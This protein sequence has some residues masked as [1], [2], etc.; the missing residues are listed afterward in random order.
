M[1]NIPSNLFFLAAGGVGRGLLLK[2]L[3]AAGGFI[4]ALGVVTEKVGLLTLVDVGVDGDWAGLLTGCFDGG[5]AAGGSAPWRLF[6]SCRSS[7]GSSCRS[8]SSLT[9]ET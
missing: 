1:Y 3:L 8:S 4:L 7:P 5:V 6:S 9:V 2:L